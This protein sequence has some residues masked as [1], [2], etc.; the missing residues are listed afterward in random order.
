MLVEERA[1]TVR[2]VLA[3]LKARDRDILVDLFYRELDRDEVCK[4]RGVTR[5]QLRLVLFRARGRFQ[6][7]WR[8]E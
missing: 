2:A 1:K 8:K 3:T 6:Q 4:Q 5:E 7:Q